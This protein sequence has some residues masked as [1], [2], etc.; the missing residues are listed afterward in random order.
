MKKFTAVLLVWLVI[1]AGALNAAGP[2][3]SAKP[4]VVD[5]VELRRLAPTAIYSGAV[6]SNF[7]ARLAA[8]VEGRLKWVAEVGTQ[9]KKGDVLAELDDIFL[10][11]ERKEEQAIIQSEQAK[12]NLH[13]KNVERYQRLVKE[14]NVAESQLDQ[15]ISDQKI[16]NSNIIASQARLAQLNER[17]AR[18]KLRAPFNG[19][20]TERF[21]Q[22]GEW[23]QSGDPL[24]RLV[25]V[26]APEIQV[27]VPQTIYPLLSLGDILE[28]INNGQLIEAKVDTIVPVGTTA[29]RLFELRLKPLAPI[30]P[31]TLVRVVIPTAAPREVLSID[32][33]ALVIRKDEISVFRVDEEITEQLPVEVGVGSDQ[34]VEII[35]SINEGDILVTR[36]GERLRPGDKVKISG[37]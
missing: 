24:V 33:D 29:S 20:I 2:G 17:I 1:C 35:G 15:S 8:E 37:N 18:S 23:A 32:R 7:D 34:Y 19:V 26:E 27:R 5:V 13:S 4:V 31:G 28:V 25:D 11:K 6:I 3:A 10:Q 14:N 22:E 30:L 21:A 36:G 12:L 9:V 16:A